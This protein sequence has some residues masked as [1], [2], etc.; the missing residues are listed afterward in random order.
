MK[1]FILKE[2]SKTFFIYERHNES[3]GY[4]EV[5]EIGFKN[6]SN[7]YK[8]VQVSSYQKGCNTDGFNNSVGLRKNEL[9]RLPFMII[10]FLLYRRFVCR[11]NRK[12]G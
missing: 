8:G 12:K 9:L 7:G 3:F 5:I 10:H 6:I 1:K 2:K 4:D 11:I